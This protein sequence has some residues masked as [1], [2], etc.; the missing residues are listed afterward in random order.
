MKRI[1]DRRRR[2]AQLFIIII[3]CHFFRRRRRT[4][5]KFWLA[6]FFIIFLATFS[7]ATFLSATFFQASFRPAMPL[8]YNLIIW[9]RGEP[10]L[11]NQSSRFFKKWVEIAV[12]VG[13]AGLSKRDVFSINSK[14]S[15]PGNLLRGW[16]KKQQLKARKQY[17]NFLTPNTFFCEIF[18]IFCQ[19][20][21]DGWA[22][23][24]H[25]DRAWF[26]SNALRINFSRIPDSKTRKV[27]TCT[28][29]QNDNKVH[30]SCTG[31]GPQR[32]RPPR[33]KLMPTR[34]Y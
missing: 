17:C 15:K 25:V 33:W 16:T 24:D 31:P 11:V 22:I 26:F 23:A 1:Y 29:L 2:I 9:L 32:A 7:P 8:I 21:H 18:K 5:H 27:L 13:N 6:R 28:L 19:N 14:L 4:F 10:L 30:R 34:Y 20:F 3:L 12:A